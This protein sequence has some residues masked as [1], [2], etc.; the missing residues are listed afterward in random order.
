MTKREALA[1]LK[2]TDCSKDAVRLAFRTEAMNHHPDHGGETRRMQLVNEAYTTLLRHLANGWN[3]TTWNQKQAN[4]DV[5][6]TE[7]VNAIWEKIKHLPKIDIELCGTWIWVSGCSRSKED[8]ALRKALK[9]AGFNFARKK[10]KWQWHPPG[11]K[12]RGKKTYSMDQIREHY[13]SVDL[14]K[15]EHSQV[16][17]AA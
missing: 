2:P 10:E 12:K 1:I 4:T 9:D 6:L 8:A 16:G 17:A 7:T 13:G 11:Y 14:D 5:P 15:D 3:W